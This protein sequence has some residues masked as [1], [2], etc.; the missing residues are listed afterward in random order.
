MILDL[1]TGSLRVFSLTLLQ[2]AEGSFLKKGSAKCCYFFWHEKHFNKMLY[3][4][5]YIKTYEM[6]HIK[7]K[8][9]HKL[10]NYSCLGGCWSSKCLN[11]HYTLGKST[12]AVT[13]N[14]GIFL[15][16]HQIILCSFDRIYA[17]QYHF[18]QFILCVFI[19]SNK[20]CLLNMY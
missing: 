5:W 13:L 6:E 17:S 7:Q 19:K 4:F 3:F 11:L 12:V 9:I 14:T 20:K 18:T 16:L 2:T 10:N 15:F 8:Y 1:I